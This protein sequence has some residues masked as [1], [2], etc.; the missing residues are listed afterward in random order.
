MHRPP[1]SRRIRRALLVTI[2]LAVFATATG[3]GASVPGS[4]N[5]LLRTLG[6][7]TFIPN[8]GVQANL[9]FS[10]GTLRVPMG[11]TLTLEHAD[12]TEAPHTLTI[13]EPEELPQT[14]EELFEGTGCPTCDAA[15]FEHVA[16]GQ[17]A[18]DGG[19]GFN[20]V[21]DS[22]LFFHGQTVE[23]DVTAEPGETLS[24]ICIIHPWMQ[25]EIEVT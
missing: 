14:I 17:L 6:D 18:V 24:Y 3:V 7:E 20:A 22:I 23:I 25:A 10:P 16:N 5:T 11:D 8:V 12:K 21:G 19:D 2:M 15:T 1:K 9:K 4:G 13:V